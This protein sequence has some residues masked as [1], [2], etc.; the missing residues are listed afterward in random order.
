MK[1]RSLLH[2]NQLIAFLI[3]GLIFIF[4]QFTKFLAMTFLQPSHPVN[5]LGNFLRLTYVE[6]PGMAFGIDISD[7]LLFNLIS[8]VAIGIIFLYYYRLRHNPLMRYSFAIIL[9]GA[10]GNLWDRLLRGS[11]VDFLDFDFFDI[12]FSGGTYLFW[13]LPSYS[14]ER[15]PVFNVADMAVTIGMLIIVLSA[16]LDISPETVLSNA[17]RKEI[18]H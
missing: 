10:F 14:L 11:V 18:S 17:H 16:F 13:Q 4:D 9:G 1:V 6:N 3:I 5:I 8:L 12:H 2:R 7:K 15:W